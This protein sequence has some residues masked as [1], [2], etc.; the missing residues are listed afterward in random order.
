M[1]EGSGDSLDLGLRAT[2]GGLTYV[3]RKRCFWAHTFGA[4]SLGS[5]ILDCFAQMEMIRIG[6]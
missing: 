5:R 6:L 2:A 4:T 3:L 1:R